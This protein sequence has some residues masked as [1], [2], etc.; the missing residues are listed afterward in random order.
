MKLCAVAKNEG[1]Y[2]ADWVFHHLHFGFDG[3]E[4]WINGTDDTSAEIVKGIRAKY[5]QVSSR[6][7]DRL[8]DD[9][10]ARGENFQRLAYKRLARKTRRQGYT[11]VAFLDLDEYWTP[12]D[13][14]SSIK[15]FLPDDPDVKVVSFPW[16]M[17]VPDLER[18]RFS[19]PL[20]GV[21][22]MQMDKHVKSAVRL[23]GSV[24]TYRE[25]TARIHG[26]L[27]L[28][29]RDPFPMVHARDQ[30]RGSFVTEDFL[31][32]HWDVLPEAFVLH[33]INRSHSEYVSSLTKGLR[34]TGMDIAYK[35]NR[36]GY[37]PTDAPVL[38]FT[39]P[40]R[41]LR[42]YAR[43]HKRFRRRIG[44][45]DAIRS[46][47]ELV[48]QRADALLEEVARRPELFEELR[49]ALMGVPGNAQDQI[50]RG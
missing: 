26:G 13:Y 37:L 10:L 33:A 15:D 34:Q 12:R 7:V 36:Y 29:V 6:T 21:T 25:H 30:R 16:C 43:K 28:L 47:Q 18:P 1:A 46:S 32:E 24:R 2:I 27:R 35:P 49:Q 4:I 8:F 22:Q 31:V 39:P 20:T 42:A 40:P 14:T 45:D 44:A 9:C 17:D 41:A 5:P 48:V 23:D 3:V 50:A 19:P 38:S 11:H